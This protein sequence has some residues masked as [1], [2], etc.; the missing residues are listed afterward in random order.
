MSAYILAMAVTCSADP[1]E[2]DAAWHARPSLTAAINRGRAYW[3]A[4]NVPEA[5]RAF[6][7]GERLAPWNAEIRDDLDAARDALGTTAPAPSFA[8]RFGPADVWTVAILSSLVA[9]VGGT[10]WEFTRRRSM[11][12]VAGAGV[13]GWCALIVISFLTMNRNEPF[14][15]LAVERAPMRTGNAISYD[16][17]SSEP[18]AL[19]TELNVLGRR[20]GWVRVRTPSGQTGWLPDSAVLF[21]ETP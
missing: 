11:L 17:Q 2:F 3:L 4:G 14:A 8:D 10:V 6:R 21:G 19:G 7:D 13:A 5:M 9:G 20:G 1:A 12:F 18:L 16:V 15:I